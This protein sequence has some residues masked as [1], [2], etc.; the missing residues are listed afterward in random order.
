MRS[1]RIS[2]PT[3]APASPA[4]SR[5]LAGPSARPA[6][7]PGS[8]PAA[9]RIRSS[10]W[11]TAPPS[12]RRRLQPVP[13]AGLQAADRQRPD[14][15]RPADAGRVHTSKSCRSTIPTTARPTR[16]PASPA[17]RSGIVSIYRRPLPS[18]NL[19]FLSTFMWDG[20]EPSFASQAI[21]ATLGHA[22]G[23]GPDAVQQA[24]IV[25]FETGI[26]TAQEFDR[27]PAGSR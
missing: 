19:G 14:P 23:T 5:R 22:Q 12:E 20:R 1:S 26:F 13:T 4:I 21:D 7:P 6:L 3:D 27:K 16:R 9:A 2:G 25:A 17:R 11:S 24:E 10:V 15:D 18:T 8:K